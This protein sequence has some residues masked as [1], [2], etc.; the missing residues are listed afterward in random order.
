[1]LISLH[2]VLPA[3]ILHAENLSR[4]LADHFCIFKF[5]APVCGA[6]CQDWAMCSKLGKLGIASNIVTGLTRNFRAVFDR[7][8]KAGKKLTI[9]KCHY[10]NTPVEF[11]CR[12]TWL[13]GVSH[14]LATSK[15]ISANWDYRNWKKLCSAV[16]DPWTATT[17]LFTEQLKNSTPFLNYQ[18]WDAHQDNVRFQRNFRLSKQS[19]QRCSRIVLKQLF[20]EKNLSSWQM[21]AS[22]PLVMTSWLRFFECRRYKWN[23][24]LRNLRHWDEKVLLPSKSW[25]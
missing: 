21:Q 12:A 15:L 3:E 10:W 16:H 24:I 13:G 4:V 1:M 5:Q 19:A 6:S 25:W 9:D 8:H 2:P 22:Q 20:L 7:F 17:I 18:K 23:K 14:K 11:R